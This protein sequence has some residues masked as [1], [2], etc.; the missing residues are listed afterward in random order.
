MQF[1][2][3]YNLLQLR[4]KGCLLQFFAAQSSLMTSFVQILSELEIFPP[5]ARIQN[6]GWQSFNGHLYYLSTTTAD[7]QTS[8]D[9]CLSK[10]ADLLII[11]DNEENNFA[12]GL[13]RKAWMG[14]KKLG[15]TWTWVD[16]SILSPKYIYWGPG[17]PN[18]QLNLEDRGEIGFFANSVNSWNDT[19]RTNINYWICEKEAFVLET[20]GTSDH[21]VTLA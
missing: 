1:R 9:D 21:S 11:N 6:E 19:P 13:N 16:G 7:W 14:L 8:R 12:R 15:S 4:K 17:E 5:T 10:G 18:N 2:N 20:L 3:V